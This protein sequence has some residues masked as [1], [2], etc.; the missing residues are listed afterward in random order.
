M[1]TLIQVLF[2][3]VGPLAGRTIS[4]GSLHYNFVDG[5]MKLV[6]TPPDMA[7]H[8]SFLEKNW[9]AYP[10]GH[11]KLEELKN[12]QRNIQESPKSDSGT[13]ID[14]GL[15][16]NGAGTEAGE[17]ENNGTRTVDYTPGDTGVF[18]D[19]D[20]HPPSVEFKA[21]EFLAEKPLVEEEPPASETPPVESE[22]APEVNQKLLKAVQNLDPLDDSQWNKDGKP[23][24]TAVEKLYGSAGITRADVEGAAPGWN[25]EKAKDALAASVLKAAGE[26]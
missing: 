22:P 13:E 1:S 15:Q 3:L 5:K 18:S 21:E 23:A 25:R 10:E 12:G 9:Q 24:M 2:F 16:P 7:L 20:G 4:L 17:Q 8:A 14:S 11:P 26:V 6:A 19:G